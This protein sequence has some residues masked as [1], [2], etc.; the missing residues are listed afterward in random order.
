MSE[1]V[2]VLGGHQTDFATNWT[3][4]DLTMFDLFTEAVSGALDDARVDPGDVEVGHVGNFVG[5]L[6]TGQGMLGGYFG[7]VHPDLAGMPA[8]RHEGAC[9]SGSLAVLAAM[10]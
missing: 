4:H 6:F 9:A 5:E 8:S 3:R 7:H 2:F 1:P 10:A